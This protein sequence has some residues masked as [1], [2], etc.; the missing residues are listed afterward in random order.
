[1]DSWQIFIGVC[2]LIVLIRAIYRNLKY[3]WKLV[4]KVI[5]EGENGKNRS[6]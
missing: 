2:I 5:K 6:H 3:N 4:D 1:M